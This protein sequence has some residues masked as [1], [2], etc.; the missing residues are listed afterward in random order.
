MTPFT[1]NADDVIDYQFNWAPWLLAGDTVIDA[2][3]TTVP[4]DLL[5]SSSSIVKGKNTIVWLTGGTPSVTYEVNVHI[6]TV[7]G[8]EK[9]QTFPL[10]VNELDLAIITS[11]LTNGVVGTPYTQNILVKGGKT[12]YTWNVPPGGAAQFAFGTTNG[13]T[14]PEWL[15]LDKNTGILS[16]SEPVPGTYMFTITVVDN[17]STIVSASYSLTVN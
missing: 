2:T 13:S 14:L 17:E 1:Q 6:T 5:V 12:P 3:W 9:D 15:S 7:Q 8:R 4:D 11:K 10:T 16:G